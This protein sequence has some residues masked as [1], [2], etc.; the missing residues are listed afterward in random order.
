MTR[1]PRPERWLLVRSRAGE[2][3]AR[4]TLQRQ[5]EREQAKWD[6]RWWHLSHRVFACAPDAQAALERERQPMPA[7]LVAQTEVVAVPKYGRVGRPRQDTQ[8]VDQESH[9]QAQLHLDLEPV[10]DLMLMGGTMRVCQA[11]ARATHAM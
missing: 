9:V 1:Y 7:W 8:P 5:A 3:R 10:K 2:Q 4:A 11:L 6:T